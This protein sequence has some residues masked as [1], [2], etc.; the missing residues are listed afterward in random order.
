MNH[1]LNPYVY[2]KYKGFLTWFG[3]LYFA[4]KPPLCSAKQIE[5]MLEVIQPA[6]VI[7]RGYNYYLD[8]HFIPGDYSHSGIVVNKREMIHS[9]AEGVGSV[10]PIDFVK[11]VDRF[12][13]LRA[14]YSPDLLLSRQM[15]IVDRAIW[16]ADCNNTEYDFMFSEDGKYYCH[17]FT[18]DC[19]AR[20]EIIISKTVKKFGV[21]PF[22]FERELYLAQNLIDRLLVVYEFNPRK[23]S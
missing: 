16:H 15:E 10:H 5:E 21:W 8:G 4:T 14:K 20:G 23:S 22:A 2:D 3:D 18:A 1:E 13:V 19:L 11:D 17:E 6:D 9:I 7:C 12:I